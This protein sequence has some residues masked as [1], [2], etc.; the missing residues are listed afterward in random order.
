MAFRDKLPSLA[1][2]FKHDDK[3]PEIG[4]ADGLINTLAHMA[5]DMPKDKRDKALPLLDQLPEAMA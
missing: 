4:E 3:A 2:I 1:G 5:V